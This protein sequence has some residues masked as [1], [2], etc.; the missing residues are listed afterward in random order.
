MSNALSNWNHI[1]AALGE[2]N[3]RRVPQL[4][5]SKGRYLN[6]EIAAALSARA[7]PA[8]PPN[9]KRLYLSAYVAEARRHG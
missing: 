6:T 3:W 1:A 5:R 8:S 7:F 2:P 4:T 9:F